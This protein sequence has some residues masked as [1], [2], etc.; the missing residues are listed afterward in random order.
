[1]QCTEHMQKARAA[2]ALREAEGSWLGVQLAS[3]FEDE[4]GGLVE[5]S[6]ELRRN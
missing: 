1:M 3:L 6:G 2:G 4:D 5:P